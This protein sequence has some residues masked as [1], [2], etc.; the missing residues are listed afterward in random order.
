MIRMNKK[1][2]QRWKDYELIATSL[3]YAHTKNIEDAEKTAKRYKDH[4]EFVALFNE[5]EM[6]FARLIRV[7]R[8][9]ADKLHRKI[10][11]KVK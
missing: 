10:H 9:K 6:Q 8:T 4:D 11:R 3:E 7:Y 1:R 2:L 5:F